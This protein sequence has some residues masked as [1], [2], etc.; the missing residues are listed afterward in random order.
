[1]D[2]WAKVKSFGFRHGKFTDNACALPIFGK[3]PG[4]LD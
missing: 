4:Y 1:M 3:T 2:F